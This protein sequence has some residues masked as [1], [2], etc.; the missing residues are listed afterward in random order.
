[1]P[2]AFAYGRD[3]KDEPYINL[4]IAAQARYLVTRDHDLLDLSEPAHPEGEQL[5]QIA[6][7]LR[8]VGPTTFLPE[9]EVRAHHA[10]KDEVMRVI[11]KT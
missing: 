6:S 11:D 5:R 2:P 9:F 10:H 8:I 4:A 3:P 1:M 7:Q